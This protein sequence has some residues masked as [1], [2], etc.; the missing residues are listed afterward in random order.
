MRAVET[1]P[2][3]LRALVLPAFVGEPGEPCERRR[4]L[5]GYEFEESR[6]IP[7]LQHPLQY[8][9]G[10]IG[11]VPTGMGKAEAAATTA[12]LCTSPRLDLRETFILSVGV[13]GIAPSMGT[14]GSVFLA[15]SIV[16]W[17][18]KYRLDPTE[19]EPVG[20]LPY[21]RRDPVYRLNEDLMA[22]VMAAVDGLPLADDAQLT[23][24][25][26]WYDQPAAR[27]E[28][29]IGVGTTVSSDEYWHGSTVADR[30]Q[31]FLDE[32]DAGPLCTTQMEDY[33]TACMLSRVGYL[34]RY[35]SVRAGSNF[36]RQPP[37]RSSRESFTAGEKRVELTVALEN[38]FRVGSAIVEYLLD[39]PR[40]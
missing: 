14:L 5:N 19:P 4:W 25:R 37:D 12:V 22:D 15:D 18:Q 36:D 34:D 21:R 38:A 11:I 31:W 32:Y 1:E 9:R 16:D 13:A 20:L 28:P 6:S 35:L 2:L 33:G 30:V 27:A 40:R 8:T 23:T 26:D 10:G 39:G 7:G 3:G 29:A 24:K 17:D